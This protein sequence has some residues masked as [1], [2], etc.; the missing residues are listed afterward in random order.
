MSQRRRTV[1]KKAVDVRDV[2]AISSV[3]RALRRK[4]LKPKNTARGGVSGKAVDSGKS[5]VCLDQSLDFLE[6]DGDGDS[7]GDVGE[8][9]A[10]I[11]GTSAKHVSRTPKTA[12]K[13]KT[14]K[15]TSKRMTPRK[16]PVGKKEVK[17]KGKGKE[18]KLKASP[19]GASLAP[20]R[21]S[22]RGR[23]VS[24]ATK[25][26]AADGAT[27]DGDAGSPL[28]TWG[29]PV[30]A[31]GTTP[32]VRFSPQVAVASP[33]AFA[34]F[35]RR[36]S[37][38]GAVASPPVSIPAHTPLGNITT[39]RR[40]S[41]RA[42]TT[43][44][45]NNDTND[46][47]EDDDDNDGGDVG[48]AGW[49]TP[50][51]EL[52]PPPTLRGATVA[53]SPA[54]AADASTPVSGPPPVSVPDYHDVI[55]PLPSP[56]LSLPS[57]YST[58]SPGRSDVPHQ[59]YLAKA[60]ATDDDGDDGDDDKNKKNKGNKKK[61]MKKKKKK[62]KKN[63]RRQASDGRRRRSSHLANMNGIDDRKP[64]S[65]SLDK[66]LEDAR[67]E[68]DELPSSDDD[69]LLARDGGVSD[70][71]EDQS[72]EEDDKDVDISSGKSKKR[73]SRRS[74]KHRRQSSIDPSARKRIRAP[75]HAHMDMTWTDDPWVAH[76]QHHFTEVDRFEL[77]VE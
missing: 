32:R 74:S 5:A 65:I 72:D 58:P 22:S 19:T 49:A 7:N 75:R 42:S 27:L 63:L 69:V 4:A 76:L 21:R 48:S 20:R 16:S 60:T 26:A 25:T 3:P 47:D 8:E 36:D 62:K 37:P 50:P 31:T 24:G 67:A 33:V 64:S 6:S 39:L 14:R 38:A 11:A 68:L 1:K 41:A 9:N 35:Q 43:P 55:S 59:S 61:E 2:S 10:P 66:T 46:D 18:K 15:K 45:L 44:T 30:L 40:R 23:D 17:G 54:A 56:V 28:A 29:S 51:R 12:E 73:K 71:E 52:S 34:G 13:S 70:L 77:V 53:N 57:D